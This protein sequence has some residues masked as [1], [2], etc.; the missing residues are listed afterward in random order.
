MQTRT[1]SRILLSLLFI[2]LPLTASMVVAADIVNILPAARDGVQLETE[3][4]ATEEAEEPVEE[5][6]DEVTE[7][8]PGVI[9]VEEDDDEIL[10]TSLLILLMGIVAVIAVGSLIFMRD[11]FNRP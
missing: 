7:E 6:T 11:R 8:A 1:L 10:G 3:E 5:T 4:D 2:G 9:V